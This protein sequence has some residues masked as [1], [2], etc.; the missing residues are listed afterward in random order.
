MNVYNLMNG[1]V[2]TQLPKKNGTECTKGQTDACIALHGIFPSRKY[3]EISKA[4]SAHEAST[5]EAVL[6]EPIMGHG[7]KKR[8]RKED[9]NEHPQTDPHQ[10]KRRSVSGFEKND[11]ESPDPNAKRKLKRNSPQKLCT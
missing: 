4:T 2:E 8:Q 5:S 7:M 6:D 1:L 3:V 11:V 10:T 9:T